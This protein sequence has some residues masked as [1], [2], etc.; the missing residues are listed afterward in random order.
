[1]MKNNEPLLSIVLPVYNSEKYV[2]KAIESILNQTFK[3]FELI[4][5]NDASKDN[6]INI[7]KK[8]SY[9][10]KRIKI[11]DKKINEGLLLAR[12]SGIN[13]A[14]GMYIGF[15]DSDD[16]IDENY[17]KLLIEGAIKTEAD[18]VISGAS[19]I[20]KNKKYIETDSQYIDKFKAIKMMDE[21]IYFNF[22]QWDKIYKKDI[23]RRII[24]KKYRGSEDI[25]ANIQAFFLANKIYYCPSMGYNYIIRSDSLSH[26]KVSL[27]YLDFEYVYELLKKYRDT[28]IYFI[29]EYIFCRE[30]LILFLR[31][32]KGKNSVEE[33][34]IVRDILNKNLTTFIDNKY[35]SLGKKMR[36]LCSAK[37]PIVICKLLINLFK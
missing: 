27:D 11:I 13:I 28:K 8:Y 33:I 20:I 23:I 7:C 24:M 6:S 19:S 15:V 17:Y 32:I 30:L 14:K 37:M 35:M 16:F 2:G 12:A 9:V 22:V 10:D 36:L 4:I 26:R 1:M 31:M 18:I 29:I 34:K 21:G 3:D 5:V 25:F